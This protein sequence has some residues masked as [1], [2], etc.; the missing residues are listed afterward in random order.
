M[1]NAGK[2]SNGQ[3]QRPWGHQRNKIGDQQLRIVERASTDVGPRDDFKFCPP[4]SNSARQQGLRPV[5]NLGL[6]AMKRK[7]LITHTIGDR[8]VKCPLMGGKKNAKL[9]CICRDFFDQ[10]RKCPAGPMVAAAGH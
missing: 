9:K 5:P 10:L 8:C 4:G 3:N 2:Q 6:T 7:Q 1:A